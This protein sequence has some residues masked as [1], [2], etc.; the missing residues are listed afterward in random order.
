MSNVNF[1]IFARE[2]M[3]IN[4]DICEG[5]LTQKYSSKRTVILNDAYR[6]FYKHFSNSTQWD[7]SFF[8]IF[9]IVYSS[10]FNSHE[11][12]SLALKECR[13]DF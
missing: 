8:I 10:T 6:H 7:F 12:Y 11:Q 13:E 1:D 3:M 9:I 4:C 2:K 5:E